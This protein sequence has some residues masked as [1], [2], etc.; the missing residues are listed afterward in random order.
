MPVW[1][2]IPILAID[3]YGHAYFYDFGNNKTAYIEAV[4]K[5][6]NWTRIGQ[7]LA[8]ARQG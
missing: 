6:L 7:R 5:S 4:M 1:N 3:L 8:A 2:T